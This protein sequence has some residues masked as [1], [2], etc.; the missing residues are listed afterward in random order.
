MPGWTPGR[1]TDHR[2]L[3]ALAVQR[4]Q[5]GP[6]DVLVDDRGVDVGDL[7][8]LGQPVDD[9]RVQRIGVRD[10][11]VQE[12][13]AAAGDQEHADELRERR[14]PVAKPLDVLPRAVLALTTGARRPALV[15]EDF[16][17]ASGAAHPGLIP[18]GLPVLGADGDELPALR[19]AALS[20]GLLVVALPAA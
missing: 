5:H 15:G 2:R 6:P 10:R 3:R 9:E 18:T 13:V 4:L 17:D 16:A 20:R 8:A 7:R 11:H 12:E 19:E 14:G 1:P